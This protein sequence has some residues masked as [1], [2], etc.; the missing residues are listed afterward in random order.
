MVDKAESFAARFQLMLDMSGMTRA[1]LAAAIPNGQQ[2]ITN[3]HKRRRVGQQSAALVREATG[4]SIEWLNDGVGEPRHSANP[5]K[6]PIRAF[7]V[8]AVEDDEGFDPAYEAWVD[9]VDIDVSAGPGGP[10]PEFV[11]TKTRQRYTLKW[12]REVGA[13]PGEVKIMAVRGDSMEPTL[14]RTDRIAI[15]TGDTKVV[16]GHV[17]VIIV[18]GEAR[19]KRLFRMADGSTRIVSDNADKTRYPDEFV[20]TDADGF[21]VIG[22]VVER[23]GTGGL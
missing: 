5:T 21:L 11:P 4:I 20:D 15:N 16:S 7:D 9:V 10:I 3:W 2:A 17:Y 22:R 8:E 19:I 23:K 14:Y 1:S 6:V 13:K 12:F 18:G